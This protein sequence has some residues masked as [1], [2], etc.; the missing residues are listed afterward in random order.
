MNMGKRLFLRTAVELTGKRRGC[1]QGNR[2]EREEGEA[3]CC[4][5]LQGVDGQHLSGPGGQVA[6]RTAAGH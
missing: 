5:R 1:Q 6:A 2:A 3:A 4:R